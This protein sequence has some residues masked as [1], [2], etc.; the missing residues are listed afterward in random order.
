MENLKEIE[1]KFKEIGLETLDKRESFTKGLLFN[2]DYNE[3]QSICIQNT[4]MDDTTT[5][6]PKNELLCPIGTKS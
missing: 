2:F 5:I 4:L 6:N 1:K 3:N